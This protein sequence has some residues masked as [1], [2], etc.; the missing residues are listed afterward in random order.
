MSSVSSRASLFPETKAEGNIEVEAETK[1]TLSR[2]TSNFKVFCYTSKL[3]NRNKNCK[4]IVCSKPPGSQIC[5]G[6]KE[7]D[8]ITCE[9]KVQVVVSLGSVS[10]F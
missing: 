10:E 9:S 4:G 6:F 1:F 5:I 2:R 3:K 7:H 8:L